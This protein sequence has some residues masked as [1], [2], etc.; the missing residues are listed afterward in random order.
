MLYDILIIFICM[1]AALG[2][3]ELAVYIYEKS[4]AA[5]LPHK[6]FILAD[7]F[8]KNDAEYVIR[9]LE[10]VISRSGT[11]AAICGIKLGENADIDV[12]L[13]KNLQ[14]EFKNIVT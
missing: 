8:E 12:D 4:C 14:K 6:F 2:I 7:N 10:G 3:T 1:F 13:L 11:D 5:R 9:F